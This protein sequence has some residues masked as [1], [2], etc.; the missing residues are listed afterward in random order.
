[1][2]SEPFQSSE[3]FISTEPEYQPCRDC[4][5]TLQTN[6]FN[7]TGD[8]LFFY[9]TQPAPVRVPNELNAET[10]TAL[11]SECFRKERKAVHIPFL[12]PE[13]ENEGDCIVDTTDRG[14]TSATQV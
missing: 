14:N 9:L 3:C 6:R 11:C 12:H 5:K 1:M 2:A 8:K 7:M 4:G 10:T 13:D